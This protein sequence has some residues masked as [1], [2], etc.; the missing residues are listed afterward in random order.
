MFT[1]S[2][3]GYSKVKGKFIPEQHTDYIFTTVKSEFNFY[4]EIIFLFIVLIITA[5][6]W[7]KLREKYKS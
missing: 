4:N 1:T 6:V 7:R 5:I 3:Q 2:Q